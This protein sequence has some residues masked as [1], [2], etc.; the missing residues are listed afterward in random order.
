MFTTPG[1]KP[2][3]GGA[4]GRSEEEKRPGST[5]GPPLAERAAGKRYSR[6]RAASARG[7]LG[8]G[9]PSTGAG[10][11]PSWPR[12]R[13]AGWARVRPTPLPSV[14]TLREGGGSP[15]QS[16]IRGVCVSV[17][18]CICESICL[19]TRVCLS[20]CVCVCLSLCVSTSVCPSVLGWR[21]TFVTTPKAQRHPQNVIS[22]LPFTFLKS[23]PWMFQRQEDVTASE[24][25]RAEPGPHTEP[26]LPGGGSCHCCHNHA[27]TKQGLSPRMDGVGL[28]LLTRLGSRLKFLISGGKLSGDG[29]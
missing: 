14:S 27:L 19:S 25:L 24:S 9:G 17:C 12:G 21:G 3:C 4:E 8:A 18:I 15:Q 6:G 28:L 10:P 7:S 1:G 16:P 26:A 5:T 11:A 22:E 13:G 20:L 2:T 29:A 23:A